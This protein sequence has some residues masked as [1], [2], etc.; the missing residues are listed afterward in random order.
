MPGKV[1]ASARPR[2]ESL[3][4]RAAPAAGLHGDSLAP[5]PAASGGQSPAAA[6]APHSGTGDSGTPHQSA[7]GSGSPVTADGSA[8]TVQVESAARAM[9][10]AVLTSAP[11]GPV[12]TVAT[13][14]AGAGGA[15]RP[16]PERTRPGDPD[17]NDTRTGDPGRDADPARDPA[18]AKRQ[19]FAPMSPAPAAEAANPWGAGEETIAAVDAARAAPE[20]DL[21]ALAD[22]TSAGA[23]GLATAVNGAPLAV[24]PLLLPG[25]TTP[26]APRP[27]NE[28]AVAVTTPAPAPAAQAAPVALDAVFRA[29]AL[30]TPEAAVTG[31]ALAPQDSID[32]AGAEAVRPRAWDVGRLDAA[33]LARSAAPLY[34]AVA[35]SRR[36]KGQGDR[37]PLGLGDAGPD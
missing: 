3:E 10:P 5:D 11:G 9:P 21:P 30:A 15:E 13:A 16:G 2:L 27:A 29:L 6:D 37:N 35:R 7:V 26:A 14:P 24:V 32:P 22:G 4:V 20:F 33:L 1:R 8:A 36:R 18:E 19:A 34:Y 28:P 17:G 31:D 23:P 12:L 25:Q